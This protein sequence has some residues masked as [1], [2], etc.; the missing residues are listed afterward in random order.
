M[1]S[2]LLRERHRVR[3]LRVNLAAD[4][5]RRL[6]LAYVEMLLLLR[7]RHMIRGRLWRTVPPESHGS[8]GQR[9]PG[10]L[11]VGGAALVHGVRARLLAGRGGRAP[12]RRV[13]PKVVVG[14]RGVQP[15]ALVG[16]AV[17]EVVVVVVVDEGG[18]DVTVGRGGVA[19]LVQAVVVEGGEEAVQ[20]WQ[21]VGLGG[22]AGP[23]G[24]P[25][26]AG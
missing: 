16:R 12:G 9:V 22:P 8:V 13:E 2:P 25:A 20:H 6:R 21:G 1:V 24:S 11:G 26:G 3:D 23:Q 10:A 14:E 7:M 4:R 5:V 19:L 15:L 18:R 17:A